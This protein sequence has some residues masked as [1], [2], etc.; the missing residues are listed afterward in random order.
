MSNQNHENKVYNLVAQLNNKHKHWINV[1]NQLGE[2]SLAEDFVQEAYIKLIENADKIDENKNIHN[3]FHTILKNMVLT[4]KN[5]KKNI[6]K[7][8]YDDQHDSP[9][10]E[11]SEEYM[12]P[13]DELKQFIETFDWYS[14]KL[15]LLWAKEGISIRKLAKE[16]GIPFSNVYYSI[17]SSKQKIKEYI[18]NNPHLKEKYNEK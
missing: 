16:I 17:K 18:D 7:E 15:Y 14:R 11:Y 12:E 5:S 3:Y 10:E 4:F 1:V 13:L 6:K 2:H 9:T 8:E